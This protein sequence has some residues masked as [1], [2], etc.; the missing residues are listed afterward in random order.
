MN[1]PSRR[2]S[3]S[4]GAMGGK[5]RQFILRWCAVK[6]RFFIRIPLENQVFLDFLK[7]LK[8]LRFSQ[9]S[10]NFSS[11]FLQGSRFLIKI[12]DFLKFLSIFPEIVI[13]FHLKSQFFFENLTFSKILSHHLNFSF[14]NKV[15][16]WIRL[17][18]LITLL[19]SFFLI[20]IGF[21]KLYFWIFD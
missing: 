1:A 16:F 18:S 9:I 6:Y 13:D 21:S 2:N 8:F 14:Q 5:R 3:R 10:F 4:S 7:F 15:R 12:I 17:G 19:G 11:I 20:L